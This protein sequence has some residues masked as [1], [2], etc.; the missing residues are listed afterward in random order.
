MCN[1]IGRR[2]MQPFAALAVAIPC[3]VALS[4]TRPADAPRFYD[5]DPLWEEASTQDG[6]GVQ[7]GEVSLSWDMVENL[8]GKPGD[9]DFDRRAMNVNTVDE[10]PDGAWFTNRAGA[11]RLTPEEVARAGSDGEGPA[12]GRWTVVSAKSDGITPGFTVRDTRGVVWFIKLDPP[13]WQGMATGTEIVAARLFWALGYHVPEYHVAKLRI[14]DFVI[15]PDAEFT[16]PDAETRAMEHRDIEWLLEQA[17]RSSDGGY[18]VSASKALPGRPLGGF[19]FY[20]TRPD[21]PNDVFPHEHRRELRG[22]GTFA[23]WLNHV[24][25]KSINTLDTV[26]SEEGRAYVR[27]H[28]LDFGSTLGSAAVFPREYWEGHE[29]LVEPKEIGKGVLGFGFYRHPWRTTR[30]YEAR[31]VGRI[32]DDPNWDPELWKPRIPNPAF[33]RARLDDKFWAARRVAAITDQMIGAAVATGQFGDPDAEA[34]LSR[35][36][37][38]RRDAI[39]RRYL[40]AINPVVN[41]TLDDDG[42]TFEN[43]AVEARVAA[44]PKGYRADWAAF[45]NTTGETRPIARTRGSGPRLRAPADLP[46]ASGAFVRVAISA[47]GAPRA[48]WEEPLLAYFRRSGT[49]WKLVG[50]DRLWVEKSHRSAGLPSI[51]LR[52]G[53]PRPTCASR[54]E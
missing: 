25:A 3:S 43:A 50:L 51:P 52:P 44:E 33:L 14:D 39:V 5:D 41:P 53:K 36:L 20:G 4:A 30:V 42:L 1:R 48:E 2:L 28:F 26:V 29:Y 16:P 18:R 40:P 35:I 11:R 32:P 12:S 7:P 21:D 54:T 17:D 37:I 34:A 9:P 23:A 27:H 13:G 47:V 31:S 8:L 24:D 49:E 46:R 6:S 19:R 15:D 38:Q 45:D 10:V 22:Y